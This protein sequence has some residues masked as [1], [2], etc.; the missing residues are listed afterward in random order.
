MQRVLAVLKRS[1][2]AD[3]SKLGWAASRAS[4][5]ITHPL[6][7]SSVSQ[8]NAAVYRESINNPEQFWGALGRQRLQWIKEFDQ[9]M[10]CDMKQGRISWFN[11]GKINVS[12]ICVDFY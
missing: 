6:Q 8:D 4:S 5:S 7:L 2:L 3:N 1:V 12:G 11:G 9:V 10:N